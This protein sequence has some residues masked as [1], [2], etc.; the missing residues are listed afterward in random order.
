M[1]LIYSSISTRS[2]IIT[3][4]AIFFEVSYPEYFLDVLG[5]CACGG[6]STLLRIIALVTSFWCAAR[7]AWTRIW[8]N[9]IHGYSLW[10]YESKKLVVA[11]QVSFNWTDLAAL[12]STSSRLQLSY[13]S[14][15]KKTGRFNTKPYLISGTS[16]FSWTKQNIIHIQITHSLHVTISSSVSGREDVKRGRYKASVSAV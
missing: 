8:C 1:V 7:F 10:E 15:E 3:L 6:S 11:G 12:E 14:W 2:K 16:V 9:T 4:I 5:R 13:T